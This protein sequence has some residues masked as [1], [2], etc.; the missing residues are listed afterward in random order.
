MTSTL[1]D[2]AMR[3]S[4]CHGLPGKYYNTTIYPVQGIASLSLKEL[5]SEMHALTPWN[6]HSL[7]NTEHQFINMNSCIITDTTLPRNI[8]CLEQSVF[9]AITPLNVKR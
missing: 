7:V 9:S 3:V 5:W 6:A 8:I 2:K 4:T 1:V